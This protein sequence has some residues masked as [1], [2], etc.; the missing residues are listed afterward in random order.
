MKRERDLLDAEQWGE[1]TQ[2]GDR[3]TARRRFSS[4]GAA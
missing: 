3:R 2:R 4:L 1:E